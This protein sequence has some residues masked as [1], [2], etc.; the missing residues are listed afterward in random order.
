[1]KCLQYKNQFHYTVCTA[2]NEATSIVLIVY[3]PSLDGPMR[4]TTFFHHLLRSTTEKPLYYKIDIFAMATTVHADAAASSSFKLATFFSGGTGFGLT[5]ADF[6]WNCHSPWHF[7]TIQSDQA[8]LSQRRGK[9]WKIEARL[10]Q[11]KLKAVPG[12][13]PVT[14]K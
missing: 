11:L 12:E 4:S 13:C 8:D 6:F 1:M 9:R 10:A 7:T 14:R 5:T 3:A 2:N